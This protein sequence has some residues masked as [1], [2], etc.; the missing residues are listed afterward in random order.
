MKVDDKLE[1]LTVY[2]YDVTPAMDT[3]VRHVL[4]RIPDSYAEGFPS[5]SVFESCS[6]WGAHVERADIEEEGKIFCNPRLVNMA[7]NV[8]I[9]ILAHEFAHLFLGH[10]GARSL[11]CE[12]QAD[13]LACQWGFKKEVR[14]M[15]R[16]LGPPTDERE[17]T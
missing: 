11:Q 14:A 16:H 7:K 2:N 8:A 6:P 17:Q 5:F 1:P 9:G 10:T 3:L 4:K 13:E 15:R 12:Y